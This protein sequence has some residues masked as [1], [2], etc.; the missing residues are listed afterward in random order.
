MSRLSLATQ[1]YGGQ[2]E[3]CKTLSQKQNKTKK[4]GLLQWLSRLGFLSPRLSTLIQLPE[5]THGKRKLTPKLSRL[6]HM[7][8]EV[9]VQKNWEFK[10]ILIQFEVSH[11][12]SYE[13]KK[14]ALKKK[15]LFPTYKTS[16]LSQ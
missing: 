2:P 5:P 13:K 1:K 14:F 6:P 15:S 7:H 11:T 12:M 3:L 9:E 10:V 4:Q 16:L 8:P